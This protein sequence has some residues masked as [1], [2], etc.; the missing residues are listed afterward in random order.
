MSIKVSQIE[1][2]KLKAEYDGVTIVSGQETRESEYTGMSPGKLMVAALGLCTGMHAVTYL[3]KNK[4]EYS[5]LKIEVKTKG[6]GN[7][8]RY[9]VFNMDIS[10]KAELSEEH[11]K[12]LV[13]ECNRC[14]VGNTMKNQPEIKID[15]KTV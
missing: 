12:G 9:G 1:G 6:A 13:E 8:A 5:D 2:Y 10:V 4:L 11:Y 15:I 14:F 3:D 7:P